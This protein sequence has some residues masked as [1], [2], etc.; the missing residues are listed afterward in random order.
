[1]VSF[2]RI[3][4]P[5]DGVVTARNTDIGQ[6]VD[7]GSSG[8]P[9]RELF[10]VATTGTLRVFVS[11][12]Q[13]ASAAAIPGLLVDVTLTERP[14]QRF[15]GKIVRNAGSID[16]ATRTLLVEIDLDN[17]NGEILPGAAVEAH[18]KLSSGVPTLL[19][20]V[21]ALMFRAEG[22]RV[23]TLAPG[24]RAHLVP[25]TL[26]RDYGTKVE[27]T[28]GLQPGTPVI[29]SPPDSLIDGQQVQVAKPA[30]P[31]AVAKPK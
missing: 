21:S 23:A 4:A 16:P 24:N 1:M 30:A 17:R 6:L 27:V 25:V 9:G 14:G 18:L 10:H 11:V 12:P 29:D 13:T 3:D 2:K 26:G 28:S 5:F 15:A 7:A 8:G 19:L 20:P 22:L 31:P